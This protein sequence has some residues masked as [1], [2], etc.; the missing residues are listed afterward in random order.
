MPYNIGQ[1]RKTSTDNT[2]LNDLS[3]VEDRI[4]VAGYAGRIFEDYAI[5]LAD[6]QFNANNTYYLRFTLRRITPT[7]YIIP[8]TATSP[9]SPSEDAQ[10]MNIKL[11][12]L[13]DKTENGEYPLGTY[14]VIQS[15]LRVEPYIADEHTNINSPYASFEIIFTPNDTY[16]YLGFVLIRSQYDYIY[17]ARNAINTDTIDLDTKGD[18]CTIN[19]ILPRQVVDK[20]GIQSRPGSLVCINREAMRI[21]RSGTLE[22]NNGIPIT[23]VGFVAPNGATSSNIDKFIFDYAWNE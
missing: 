14:Q 10:L 7:D 17:A 13:K 12:L 4:N 2:Y 1:I 21:G 11:Q 15:N 22:I 3:I 16:K 6:G 18:V 5:Q 23:F 8:A 9:A 20:I 19:N